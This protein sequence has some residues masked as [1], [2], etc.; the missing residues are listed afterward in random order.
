MTHGLA[1]RLRGRVIL[2]FAYFIVRD[3]RFALLDEV[4]KRDA[5]SL[6]Q[7]RAHQADRLTRLFRVSWDHNPYWRERFEKHGVNPRGSDPFAEL[8]KLPVLTKD[9]LRANWKRMRST[10]LPDSEVVHESSSGSTG[11][12]INFYQ[13]R[14]HRNLHS[15]MEYR[16]RSWM[17]IRPGE[18]YLSI[19]SHGAHLSRKKRM[20]RGIRV[21]LERDFI[22]DS[23]HIDPERVATQLRS[24]MKYNPVHVHG[25]TTSVVTIAKVSE[26]A[27]LSWPSIRAVST[28]S[29]PQFRQDRELLSRVFSSQVYDR[30]G[31]REI[32]SVSMQCSQGGHHIYSDV[33]IIEFEPFDE[34]EAQGDLH[35]LVATPLDNEAM[36][37]FRYRGGDEAS[38][39]EGACACGRVLPLMTG[40]RGRIC[41]NFVTPDGRIVNSTYFLFFFFY[42][43]GFK[44]YQFHQTSKEHID[45]YVVP[46]GR[47]TAERRSYLEE[48]CQ[49]IRNDFESR[50]AVDLHVVDEI[51]KRPGG[52]HL[53]MLS[54][55]LRHV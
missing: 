7:I 2:P 12:Q 3:A 29:E 48:C 39:V 31:S 34:V 26:K 8:A 28:T 22:I 41:N 49:R 36:P 13:S 47:L 17:G 27:G 10:H 42:Q 53:F 55:V 35:A 16:S 11:M 30:Y 14:F 5:W 21:W 40:C 50:W 23:F 54:D 32:L 46:D 1:T 52:K 38:P 19:Q 18:P 20:L 9:E 44:S 45:L 15:A 37:I 51:P 43:E 6:D 24:A 4:L 25:Y 33:N